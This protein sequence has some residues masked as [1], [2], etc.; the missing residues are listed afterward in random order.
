MEF[1]QISDAVRDG[2][3]FELDVD[4]PSFDAPDRVVE[5]SGVVT[6]SFPQDL[7]RWKM[8]GKCGEESP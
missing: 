1:G 8:L 6:T 2:L 7:K 5:H 3:G 4:A